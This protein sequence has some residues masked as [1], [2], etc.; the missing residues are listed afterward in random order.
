MLESQPSS[1]KWERKHV[2]FRILRSQ[3]Q[4]YR[5][6]WL[7]KSPN[8]QGVSVRE[9]AN[10]QNKIKALLFTLSSAFSKPLR[11]LRTDR[12]IQNKSFS[13]LA[14]SKGVKTTKLNNMLVSIHHG[15]HHYYHLSYYR[16]VIGKTLQF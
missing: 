10:I 2:H 9:S 5:S 4:S 8:A 15:K 11:Q 3:S 14:I 7:T 12:N 6:C 16:L 1:T 13:T